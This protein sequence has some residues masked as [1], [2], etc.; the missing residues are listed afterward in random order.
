[1]HGT[2]DSTIHKML[3]KNDKFY[4]YQNKLYT[5][6]TV[7]IYIFSRFSINWIL[8]LECICTRAEITFI[9]NNNLTQTYFSTSELIQMMLL[10]SKVPNYENS[11][12]GRGVPACLRRVLTLPRLGCQGWGCQGWGV[13]RV[14]GAKGGVGARRVISCIPAWLGVSIPPGKA[15]A[16]AFYYYG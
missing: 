7:Y 13:Q 3:L 2:I 14:G 10:L 15:W 4:N 1:M 8:W 16:I 5:T 9:F 6:H 11:H 12:S